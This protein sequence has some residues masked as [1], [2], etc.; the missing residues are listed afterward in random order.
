MAKQPTKQSK[1]L[2]NQPP[3]TTQ[4][5]PPQANPNYLKLKPEDEAKAKARKEAEEE[6]ESRVDQ[7]WFI[8][9]EFGYYYGYAG[10]EAILNNKIPLSTV[11]VLVEAARKVWY[12]KVQDMSH[13]SLVAH[14]A[15][16]AGKK[17][18]SVF[19]KGMKSFK[20]AAR[21]KQ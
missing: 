13:G 9:A 1:K 15:S 14:M 4:P 3:K 20:K 11:I 8:I 16:R 18:T 12:G 10:I 21:I 6:Q 2:K 7:E 5:N 19:S 17:A